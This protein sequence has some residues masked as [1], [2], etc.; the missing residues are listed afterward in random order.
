MINITFHF[1]I[2]ILTMNVVCAIVTMFNVLWI[3]WMKF[4]IGLCIMQGI[5]NPFGPYFLT[6]I[7]FTIRA[8]YK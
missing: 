3:Y 6:S 5:I 7:V 1:I 4:E 8:L 2:H